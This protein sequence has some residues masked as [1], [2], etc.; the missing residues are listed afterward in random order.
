[1]WKTI[2]TTTLALSVR[3]VLD[4]ITVLY[5]GGGTVAFILSSTCRLDLRN[6]IAYITNVKT[7]PFLGKGNLYGKGN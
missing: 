4:T 1:M 5:T 6:N 7:L 3:V 2:Y